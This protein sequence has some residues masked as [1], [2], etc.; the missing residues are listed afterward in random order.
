M[1]LNAIQEIEE[2]K[3]LKARYFRLMNHKRWDGWVDVFAEDVIAVI[4]G[5]T[6]KSDMRDGRTWWHK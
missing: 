3:K 2:I 1:E 4:E 5:H 6:Q